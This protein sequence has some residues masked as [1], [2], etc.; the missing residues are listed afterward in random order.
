MKAVSILAL[1]ASLGLLGIEALRVEKRDSPAVLSLPLKKRTPAPSS[2]RSLSKRQGEVQTPDI[3]YNT[4]L[5][6]LVELQIGTPP[7]S[8][9]VQL[10]TGSSDLIVETPSSHICTANTSNPC[11]NFGPCT[12]VLLKYREKFD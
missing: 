7:Q 4:Q 2:K 10:D 11:T 5:L 1:G 8:T 12:S 9:Y 6:Y 3:N